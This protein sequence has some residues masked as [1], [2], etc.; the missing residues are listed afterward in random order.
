MKAYLR[1]TVDGSSVPRI[2]GIAKRICESRVHLTTASE[3]IK[4]LCKREVHAKTFVTPNVQD[5]LHPR[6]IIPKCK[7]CAQN[8]ELRQ[9]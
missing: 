1:N 9:I 2:S 4:G 3:T 5:S 6:Q 7:V 8:L